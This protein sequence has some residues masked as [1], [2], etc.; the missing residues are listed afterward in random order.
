MAKV[1]NLPERQDA[2]GTWHMVLKDACGWC[3]CRYLVAED[4][5]DLVWEPGRHH[6]R[7]CSDEACECHTRARVGRRHDEW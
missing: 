1:L 5:H 4:D 6:D 3:G 2:E 7:T